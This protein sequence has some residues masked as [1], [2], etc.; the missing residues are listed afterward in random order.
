MSS[1]LPENVI[2]VGWHMGRVNR[3]K[4]VVFAIPCYPTK[5]PF[6]ETTAAIKAEIPFLEAAGW[7]SEVIYQTGLPY[8]SAARALLLHSALKAD[9]T[10]I[11]FV[12]QDISWKPGD[13]VKLIETEGGMVAGTYRY[14]DGSAEERYMGG[15]REIGNGKAARRKDGCLEAFMM[16][17]GFL[18][19]TREAVNKMIVKHPEL[20]CGEASAPHY[21]MFSHGVIEGEWRGEDSAA[22]LRWWRMGEKVWCRPDLD[23]THH[24]ADR[25]YP[26]NL[27][28]YL[29]RIS[30][31]S[32]AD[33]SKFTVREAAN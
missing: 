19:V 29:E 15:L 30:G 26:G 3:P 9:A 7:G 28:K 21:D 32:V 5:E 17:A 6:P 24:S 12:D 25:A 1:T 10:V 14:K 27:A 20:C 13:A 2:D 8:I 31:V 11:L 16:P 4:K 23:I 22:C 18:K 33:L